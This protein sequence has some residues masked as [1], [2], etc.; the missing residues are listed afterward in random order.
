MNKKPSLS[1]NFNNE[2]KGLIS[3]YM[4]LH[5]W[6]LWNRLWGHKIVF[7]V[8]TATRPTPVGTCPDFNMEKPS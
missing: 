1:K 5:E 4:K 3:R 8:G 2:V 7:E 6:R